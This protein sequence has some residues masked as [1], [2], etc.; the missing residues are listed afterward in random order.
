MRIRISYPC[1]FIA[2]SVVVFLAAACGT[3]SSAEDV[4]TPATENT[5]TRSAGPSSSPEPPGIPT[6][7]VEHPGMVLQLSEGDFWD[8]RWEWSDRS[9]S[10]GSG[11]REGSEDGVFRVTLGSSQQVSG[12]TLFEVEVTGDHQADD[13]AVN[14]APN[15][16][17]LGTDGP[18]LVASSDGF[19]VTTIFDA[20]DGEWVGGGFFSRFQ[21]SETHVANLTSVGTQEFASWVGVES[22]P[23][24][25]VVRSD[26]E[27]MCEV[28]EGRRICPRDD[29][30][31]ISETQYYRD[32]VGP[33][34]YNYRASASFSGGGFFSSNA[35]EETVALTASSL[36]GDSPGS[37]AVEP[38]ST[39]AIDLDVV[40]GPQDGTL[41]LTNIDDQIPDFE[42]GVDIQ[43]GVVDV[44]FVN[45]DVSGG[46][47]SY[48]VTFR[49]SDEETFH[50]VY[51]TSNGMWEHF[52]RGGSLESHV[53]HEVGSLLLNLGNGEENRLFV[54][55]NLDEA[56]FF[57]NGEQVAELDLS[58][59]N[60]RVSGD[61]RAMIGILSTDT[62]DG[63]TSDFRDLV[64]LAP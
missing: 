33:F 26:S 47:W 60:A 64:I 6:P 20:T 59:A 18:L 8:Y 24:F 45:P 19:S 36:L 2:T 41:M 39:P 29:S 16:K 15:W 35:S 5:P 30:F 46:D 3:D 21:G 10:Q 62:Y 54:A 11:C 48:G 61:V 43:I 31:S 56:A 4:T 17:Y 63:S 23:A 57:V 53:S 51:V 7:V 12:T 28:I 9:C 52:S 37:F 40:F 27:S 58:T 50:A 49:H 1:L 32:E 14:F 42:A 34:G 13:G 22:G 44:T 55:F 38:T 25:S